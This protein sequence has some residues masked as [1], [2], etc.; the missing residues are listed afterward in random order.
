[1]KESFL[2]VGGILDERRLLEGRVAERELLKLKR[3]HG[4]VQ[5]GTKNFIHITIRKTSLHIL[6]DIIS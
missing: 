6:T 4:T 1:M 5:V 3:E 2:D